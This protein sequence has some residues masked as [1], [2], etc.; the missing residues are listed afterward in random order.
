MVSRRV[1]VTGS[2]L[3]LSIALLRGYTWYWQRGAEAAVSVAAA[4]LREGRPIA[5]LQVDADKAVQV[6]TALRGGYDVVSSDNIGLGF[7]AYEVKVRSGDGDH[8]N[9]DAYHE[10]D[11]WRLVCCNHFRGGRSR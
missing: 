4:A 7:R 3:L 5:D 10:L 6:A 8:Y 11:G 1:I 9:F 2:L